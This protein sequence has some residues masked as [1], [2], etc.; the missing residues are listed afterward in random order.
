MK[1][2]IE[3]EDSTGATGALEIDATKTRG[4]EL[5]AEVTEFPVESGPA[6]IDHIRP[7]NGTL[8]IEGVISNTPIALPATQ[9][10][11][12][13]QGATTVQVK[14]PGGAVK[15]TLYQWS[16]PIDRRR[17]CD[18]ILAG[19]VAAGTPVRVTTSLRTVESL[20]I[21]RYKVDENATTGDA[22]PLVLE[23]KALRVATVAR[24]AVPAVR[25]LQVPQQRGVQPADDRSA[26]ARMLD[27]GAPPDAARQQARQAERRRIGVP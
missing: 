22:L 4:F 7:V 18:A 6:V 10:N 1:T 2:L 25:R 24:A 9:M 19:L 27:G 13:T 12:V 5:A 8:A 20:A 3:W 11:G 21:A 15:V 26:A 14:G 23:F 17:A 16:G